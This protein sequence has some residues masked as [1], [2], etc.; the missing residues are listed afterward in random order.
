MSTQKT[1]KDLS[2]QKKIEHIWEYYKW[3][4]IGSII[5]IVT[6]TSLITTMLRP[7]PPVYP[8][9]MIVSGK[10]IYNEDAFEEDLKPFKETLGTDIYLMPGDWDS[11]N[12]TTMVNNQMLMLKFQVREGDVLAISPARHEG[13]MAIEDFD[14]F[15]MLDELPGLEGTLEA[16]K[17]QLVTGISR[18]DGKEHVF[19]IRTQKINDLESVDLKEEY[20]VSIIT[21]PK[22]MEAAINLVNYILK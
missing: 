6:L 2:R 19:G 9:N 3:H 22:D 5:G 13:F 7:R 18:E 10:M 21:Q 1:F 16:Y 11:Q 17:D 20:I 4:I 12:Q 8:V 14:T 15:A